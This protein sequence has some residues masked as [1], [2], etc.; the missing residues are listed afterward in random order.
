VIAV[1]AVVALVV[2][3][4]SIHILKQYERPASRKDQIAETTRAVVGRQTLDSTVVFPAPLMSTIQELGAFLNREA[5]A[6]AA[7]AQ[8]SSNGSSNELAADVGAR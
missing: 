5:N 2:A 3:A 4:A 1:V 6:A 7:L 8:L